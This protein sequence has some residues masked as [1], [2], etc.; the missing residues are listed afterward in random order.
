[1]IRTVQRDHVFD[2]AIGVALPDTGL[3]YVE[4]HGVAQQ[5]ADE[6]SG[7]VAA[8]AELAEGRVNGPEQQPIPGTVNPKRNAGGKRRAIP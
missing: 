4:R 8:R 2:D 5:P 3:H 6:D 1:M 7:R